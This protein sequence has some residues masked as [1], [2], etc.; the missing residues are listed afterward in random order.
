VTLPWAAYVGYFHM[1][2]WLGDQFKELLI[3]VLFGTAAIIAIY[4]VVRRT[5]KA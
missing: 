4:A 5:G 3:G 1:S 2:G